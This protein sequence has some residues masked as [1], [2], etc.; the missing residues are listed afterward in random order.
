M[1][2][3]PFALAPSVGTPARISHVLATPDELVR[4]KLTFEPSIETNDALFKSNDCVVTV[5]MFPPAAGTSVSIIS[6]DEVTASDLAAVPVKVPVPY[7][8]SSN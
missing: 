1:I 5:L 3:I 8:A 7:C 6:P 4:V 2:I